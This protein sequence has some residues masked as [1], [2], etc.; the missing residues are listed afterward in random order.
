MGLSVQ[1]LRDNLRDLTGDDEDDL[2]DEKAN[3]YLNMAWW[4]LQEKVQFREN[5]SI[6]EFPLVPGT[7]TYSPAQIVQRFDSILGIFMRKLEGTQYWKVIKKEY[8]DLQKE[9][10]ISGHFEDAPLYYARYNSNIVFLPVP[11]DVYVCQLQFRSTLQDLADQDVIIPQAWHEFIYIGAG[12]RR[13]RDLGEYARASNLR[14]ERDALA[15]SLPDDPTKE[16]VDN[17]LSGVR[18]LKRRYP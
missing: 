11:N 12:I 3:M 13:F 16:F 8:S 2:P 17:S 14:T 9:M 4:E 18:V 15:I 1:A 5:E 10:N 6:F 7:N